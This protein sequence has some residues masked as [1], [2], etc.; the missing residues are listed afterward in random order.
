MPSRNE[1]GSPLTRNFS[2]FLF[3]AKTPKKKALGANQ[4]LY[5]QT[6]LSGKNQRTDGIE[7]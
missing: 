5:W 3:P 1:R 7:S 2:L 4:A 6:V